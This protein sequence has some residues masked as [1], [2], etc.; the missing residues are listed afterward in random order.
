MDHMFHFDEV[1][2]NELLTGKK[3]LPVGETLQLGFTIDRV[4]TPGHQ[5]TQAIVHVRPAL[6][7]ENGTALQEMASTIAVPVGARFLVPY[8]IPYTIELAP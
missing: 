7:R 2:L 6:Y 1:Y 3:A 5:S 4:V 8:R